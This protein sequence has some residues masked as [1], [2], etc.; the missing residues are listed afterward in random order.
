MINHFRTLLMNVDGS[1]PLTEYLAEEV[2]DPGFKALDL[3]T[4]A[5]QVRRVLFGADPDRHMLNYRCRQLL[6]MVHATPLL[7]YVTEFDARLT[8]A[9][10][11][12]Q[13]VE[14]AAWT[15]QVGWIAGTGDNTLTVLG[16]PEPP[17]DTGRL[18]HTFLVTVDSPGT[19]TVERV[20]RPFSK[21]DFGFAAAERIPLPGSG[22][23]CRLSSTASGQAFRV[24]VRSRPR[25][26][27]GQLADAASRLGEPVYNYLFGITR[28][29]PYLTF[30]E[31]WTRK[32]EL[33]LRLAALVCALVYRSEEARTRG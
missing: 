20:S 27:L 32:R 31:L 11:G 15:P 26:D 24:D 29:Q 22:C 21:V 17:D 13:L 16:E 23:D 6:A 4:P 14:P 5:D 25:R 7:P 28:T 12:R 10:A 30:R 1:V 18:A 2:V 3:P 19:A 33:P 9:F 8:Y